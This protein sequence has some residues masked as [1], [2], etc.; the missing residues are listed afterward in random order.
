M[1]KLQTKLSCFEVLPT[2]LYRS[3]IGVCVFIK[4]RESASNFKDPTPKFSQPQ[5]QLPKINEM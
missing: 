5:L 1:T 3:S 4:E 2:Y